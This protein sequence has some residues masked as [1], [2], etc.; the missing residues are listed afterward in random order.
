MSNLVSLESGA[1][2]EQKEKVDR[3]VIMRRWFC[4]AHVDTPYQ[5]NG[6]EFPN[7]PERANGTFEHALLLESE[8]INE[9]PTD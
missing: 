3:L 1:R 4:C 6:D 8:H 2:S 9:F 5:E 7:S